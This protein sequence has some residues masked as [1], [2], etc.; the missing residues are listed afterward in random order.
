[1]GN[2]V[3]M[4]EVHELYDSISK[5]LKTLSNNTKTLKT[6]FENLKSDDDFKGLTASNINDYNDSFHIETINRLDKIKEEF[7]K[8]FDNAI[9]S[10]HSSVDN[11]HSAILNSDSITN[12]KDDINKSV[13]KIEETKTKIN[14][15]IGNVRELTSAKTITNNDVKHKGKELVK[16]IKKTV[17]EFESFQNK[18]CGDDID[19][20]AMI[21]PVATMTSKVNDMPSSRSTIAGKSTYIKNQYTFHSKNNQFVQMKEELGKYENA[22]YGGKDFKKILKTMMKLKDYMLVATIAGDGDF[23]K[24]NQML[25]NNEVK[26]L[27]KKKLK[28]MNGIMNTDVENLKSERIMKA[29][30]FLIKNPKNMK[31]SK[32]IT[33]ALKMTQNFDDKELKSI[34][35]VMGKPTPKEILKMSGKAALGEIVSENLRN[36][37]K[38]PKSLKGI[39]L[40]ELEDFKGKNFLGKG[41]KSLK[42]LGKGLGPLGVLAAVGSNVFSEKSGQR[43]A[44][45]SAVDLGAI[46]ATTG[47][48]TAIGAGIGGPLGAGIGAAAGVTLGLL[49]EVKIFK[50]KKSATD[51]VKDKANEGVNAMKNSAKDFGKTLGSIF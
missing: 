43:K 15:E 30:D 6:N 34:R 10:F 25:K 21:A 1:M 50:G 24:G 2:K 27:G 28:L 48:G 18:H 38:N 17:K 29:A 14:I 51:V 44:V 36:F 26:K 33:S 35:K 23:L 5:G 45:D 3:K 40:K 32:K 37:I 16:H 31:K 47:T 4:D 22:A 41:L 8:K 11:D 13:E 12:Y 20:L 46:A 39:T 7:E 9:K 42:Y 19:L 49:T